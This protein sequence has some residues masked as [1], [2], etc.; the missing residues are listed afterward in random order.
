MRAAVFEREVKMHYD[1]EETGIRVRR[2]FNQHTVFGKRYWTEPGIKMFRFLVEF[3]LVEAL[4]IIS[5]F[6]HESS[7]VDMN[8]QGFVGDGIVSVAKTARATDSARGSRVCIRKLNHMPKK[9]IR[10]VRAK[11]VHREKEKAD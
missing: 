8:R 4:L 9:K 3:A 10:K 7:R 6:V 11:G 5:G 2:W 1:K